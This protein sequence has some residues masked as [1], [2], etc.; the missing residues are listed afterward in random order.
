MKH[1]C[2]YCNR[3]QEDKIIL[4]LTPSK[5]WEWICLEC[6]LSQNA[7]EWN[8]TKETNKLIR[9]YNGMILEVEE[10]GK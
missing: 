10:T 6:L 3:G 2:K 4:I 1:K 7:Q 9:F 5:G 8:D